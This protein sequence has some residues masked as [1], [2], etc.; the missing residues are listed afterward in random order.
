MRQLSD[1]FR[2]KPHLAEDRLEV[3]LGGTFFGEF[4]VDDV[5]VRID[6]IAKGLEYIEFESEP[7]HLIGLPHTGRVDLKFDHESSVVRPDGKSRRNFLTLREDA[8]RM[9]RIERDLRAKSSHVGEF[10]LAPKPLDKDRFDLLPV[11]IS[12]KI[13][14]MHFK[15]TPDRV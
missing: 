5:M 15:E 10:L 2:F 8:P 13:Q 4:H 3:V 11:K 1:K 7:H 6:F 14:Q 9:V 12:G